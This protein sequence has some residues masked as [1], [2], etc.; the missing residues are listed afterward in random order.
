MSRYKKALND[1]QA[2]KRSLEF[3]ES[4]KKQQ[5]EK[6]NKHIKELEEY[7]RTFRT[8]G[9]D[10]LVKEVEDDIKKAKEHIKKLES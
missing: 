9:R 1:I 4:Q 3:A 2:E 8:E 7:K 6:I 10:D 5:I